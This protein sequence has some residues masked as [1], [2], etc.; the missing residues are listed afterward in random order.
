MAEAPLKVLV[1][2]PTP[3]FADRGCHVRILEEARAV[4]NEGVQLHLVTYHIGRDAGGF[5]IDRIPKIPWYKKLG[6]GPSWHKPYLDLLLLFKA[7]KV[8]RDFKP[9]LIHAHLHEGAFIGAILKR[10]LRIPM[11]FDCQGSLTGEIT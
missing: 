10:I 9:D 8:A 6:A 5:P 3:Y 4:N 2:A 11:L 1:L 7:L